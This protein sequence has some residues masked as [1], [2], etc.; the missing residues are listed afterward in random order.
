MFFI[1]KMKTRKIVTIST[2]LIE[3]YTYCLILIKLLFINYKIH[4]SFIL[5]ICKFNNLINLELINFIIIL[6]SIKILII[7][8]FFI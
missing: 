4:F 5:Y 6:I 7:F 8:T 3:I 1:F 2:I